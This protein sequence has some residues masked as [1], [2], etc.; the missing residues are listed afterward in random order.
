[1]KLDLKSNAEF[2]SIKRDNRMVS[3]EIVRNGL[4]F[5]ALSAAADEDELRVF[6][7]PEQGCGVTLQTRDFLSDVFLRS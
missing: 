7:L 3:A 2:R 5:L 4:R 6:V 1:M